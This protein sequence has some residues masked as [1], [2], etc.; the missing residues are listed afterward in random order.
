MF[1]DL[2]LMLRWWIFDWIDRCTAFFGGAKS[3]AKIQHLPKSPVSNF[4]KGTV[5]WVYA[6]TIG[7]IHAVHPLLTALLSKQ[8]FQQLVILTDHTHYT[9]AYLKAFPKAVIVEHGLDGRV[10]PILEMFP[11]RLFL[12]AEIPCL[13]SD[14]PCRFS[15]RVL[16]EMK[17]HQTPVVVVNGWLYGEQP[18]CRMDSLER[19][20]FHAAYLNAID[21]FLVQNQD[22]YAGLCQ[23]GADSHKICV[24]GNLKFDALKLDQ[25]HQRLPEDLQPLLN[26]LKQSGRP[27]V[28][29]GC[30][31]NISEQEYV[32]DAFAQILETHPDALLVLAP[33]HPENAN[34]MQR[35]SELLA[36]RHL[37]CQLRSSYELGDELT[38]AVLVLDTMG[39]LRHL[40]AVSDVSYVGLNHNVLEPLA[41]G[42]PVVVGEGWEPAYPSFPVYRL[43]MTEGLIEES[44]SVAHLAK[45]FKSLLNEKPVDSMSRLKVLEQLGGVTQIDL[46]KILPLLSRKQSR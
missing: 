8:E 4:D 24:T 3:G 29:A 40:Y 12:I 21:L 36:E 1:S 16:R 17:R 10:A 11:P 19:E 14:A 39:E 23:A 44:Y 26:E 6:S 37:T 28:V 43:S 18:S 5:L 41:L 27:C 15:Y 25:P 32:L 20:W 34:R 2:T 31:T 9:D 33:R 35:L 22:V 42:K 45:L 46:K 30:I 7:E 38:A 13:L